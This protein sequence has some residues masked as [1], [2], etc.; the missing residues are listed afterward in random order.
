MT[1]RPATVQAARFFEDAARTVAVA[2]V[3]AL[4]ATLGLWYALQRGSERTITAYFTSTVGLYPKNAVTVQGVPVGSVLDVVPQGAV[5]RVRLAV[6]NEIPVGAGAQAVI[7]APSLVSDRS[8]QLGPAYEGGPMMPDGGVIPVTRTAAPVELDRVY[9]SLE[10][11][12]TA[13]GPNGANRTGALNQLLRSSADALGGN[14][15]LLKD[16]IT[17]LSGAVGTLADGRGD[18]FATVDGLGRFT[19]TLAANDGQV[20]ALT[21][22]LGD[23]SAFV[24]SERG[25]LSGV[26]R[27]LPPALEDV[28]RFVRDHR[29]LLRTDVAKLRTI[30]DVLARQRAALAELGDAAPLAL[31]NLANTYDAASG[32]VD[33]RARTPGLDPRALVCGLLNSGP[34]PG[35]LGALPAGDPLGDAA[36]RA[37]TRCAGLAPDTGALTAA[38]APFRQVQ[39]AL[40]RQAAANAV[41]PPVPPAAPG[42]PAA[43]AGP[44]DDGAVVAPLPP[45]AGILG[46]GQTFGVTP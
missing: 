30:T 22:Q 14:G 44:A 42:A 35:G 28:A 1:R 33:V 37:Q 40:G 4:L 26:L 23:V 18:L 5:V 24:S 7:L 3:V 20:R 45:G 17:Q 13:L 29:D 21:A 12:A 46:L 41:V 39:G 43:T 15:A 25:S 6:D 8:V 38:L 16:T 11:L 34:L 9:R 10:Q 31:G 27:T 2:L 19:G 36:A 32:T